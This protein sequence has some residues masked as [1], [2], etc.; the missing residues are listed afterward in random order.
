MKKRLISILAIFAV[1]ASMVLPV[2][3]GRTVYAANDSEYYLVPVNA[4]NCNVDVNGD[5]SKLRLWARGNGHDHTWTVTENGEYVYFTDTASG[6]VIEVPN[7]NAGNGTQLWVNQYDGSD[8]QLW[9]LEDAGDDTYCIKSKLNE[10]FG[11]DNYGATTDNGAQINVHELNRGDN[12][13]FRLLPKEQNEETAENEEVTKGLEGFSADEGFAIVP[14]H[15]GASAIDLSASDEKTVQLFK[16]H[17]GDNQTWKVEKHGDYV[18]FRSFC[19]DKVLEVPGSNTANGTRLKAAAYD[20]SDKQLWELDPVGDG[21]YFIR[22]KL[23]HNKVIDVSGSSTGN[24]TAIQL[25]SLN[26]TSAQRFRFVHTTTPEPMNEWGA[27]RHDCNGSNWDIWDGTW[28]NS[29]YY[30]NTSASV[31]EINTARQLAGLSQLVRD[32]VNSFAGRTIIL[33]R[34]INLAGIEWR[35]IGLPGHSFEGSFNGGGHAIIGLSITT[36]SKQDGFFGDVFRGSITN[37]AIK[38]SVQGD[39][40]VGGVCG[41]LHAGHIVDV[42]SEVSLIKATDDYEGGICGH[43]GIDTL[44]DHC[45]QNARVNSG[46]QDPYRGGIS[47]ASHGFISHC[48]N[49]SS[50]DCNW[51]Y[52]GGITGQCTDGIIE[53]CANYGQI[54]GGDD[55]QYAGGIAGVISSGAIFACYNSGY[56]YSSDDDDI[57]GIAGER[58]ESGRVFC[59]INTGPVRGDDYVGGITGSGWCQY[60]FNA[61]VVTGDDETGA[62]S[63]SASTLYYCRALGWTNG[64]L[65]GDSDCAG[66]GAEWVSAG[67]VISGKCCWYLN[68]GGKKMDYDAINPWFYKGIATKN[69]FRQNLGSD[70]FPT[71]SGQIVTNKNGKYTNGEDGF[72]V[73]V[74]CDKEYGSVDGG[75]Y[76]QSG[77]VELKAEPADGCVFDHFEVRSTKVVSKGMYSGNHDYPTT[78]VKEYND[79]V[80]TLTDDIDRSYRIKA[81]FKVFDDTP[82]DLKQKVKIEIE[83]VDD[84]DGWNSTTTPAYLIDS[85]GE[86]HLWEIPSGNLDGEGKKVDHTFDIGTAVPIALEVYPDFGGGFTFHDLGLKAR[87]WINGAGTAIE[88]VKVMINSYPFVSS[89]YGNDYMNITFGDSGNSQV[90]TLAEDGTF[91]EK[92]TYTKCSDAWSAVQKLG[93]GACV[94]MTSA[95]LTDKVLTLDGSKKITLDLNGY[96]MI[97]TI[98]KASKNG[99]LIKVDTDA[100]LNIIDSRPD[101]KTCSAFTGGSIQGGRS[102]NTGGLIDVYGTLGMTGGTLYNGGTTEDGGAIRVK[103]GSV[104]LKNTLISN[105]WANKAKVVDNNGGGIAIM[106]Q[107]NVSLEN[108]TIRACLANEMGGGIYMKNK[109]STLTLKNTDILGCKTNDEEGGA[110]HQDNG[111]VRWVGG[112][113]AGCSADSDDGGAIWQNNGELY[114]EDIKFTDNS[115]EDLGGAV[116]INTDDPTYFVHCDFLRNYAGDDGGAIYLDDNNLYMDGCSV[117]ANV[118]K[119]KGGGLY[120]ESSGS[121]DVAGKMT[122]KDNDGA[123]SMDNL[124]IEKG[125][126]VYN[127]GLENGSKIRLRSTKDGEIPLAA[128]GNQMSEYQMK[129]CFISDSSGG[130]KL[131]DEKTLSTKLSASAFSPGIIAAII[132]GVLIILAGA[133]VYLISDKNRKGERS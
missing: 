41:V 105:C 25:Y 86:K 99:E 112:T 67:D 89:K 36:S 24:G 57:G 19:Y 10:D 76:Y 53:Y 60:C 59:C 40:E 130:L 5:D 102:S 77:R 80:F 75:G 56:I 88:S 46:D 81:V 2:L 123:E 107:A 74:E 62:V 47:G 103:S 98:K 7:G 126:W 90:G 85:A 128:E 110:I 50:V 12:Q 54:S 122:I 33:R 21:G 109:E 49:K 61:G 84:T 28:D 16:A 113:A 37:F 104:S 51:D 38:G 55:T 27:T 87:M 8:K 31:Y 124:V 111:K 69:V 79:E 11:M 18:S 129:N 100:K 58:K 66:S 83:C 17:K 71:F 117:I 91:T 125:A 73:D 30:S 120:L 97:R 68:E 115:C 39:W 78:E 32:G 118:S 6:K 26:R 35:R 94:R 95:W 44:I 70:E 131:T 92:G 14:Q 132:G 1:I 3:P 133:Y 82:D 63:G 121:I 127:M 45:T 22:S 108:C 34:D 116:M 52:V 9:K 15:A 119:D 93:E 65:Q 20:G 72:A 106:D 23:D 101:S 64:R 43:N 42:Y 48:V 114:C 29:W 13:R 4:P 96:P